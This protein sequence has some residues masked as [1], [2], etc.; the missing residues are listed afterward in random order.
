MLFTIIGSPGT[1]KG[2]IANYLKE[3]HGFTVVDIREIFYREIHEEIE[4]MS[5]EDALQLFYSSL[6]E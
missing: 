6:V 4:A 1:G 2:L 3:K 5:P